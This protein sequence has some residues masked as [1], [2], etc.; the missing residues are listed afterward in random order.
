[1]PA[2]APAVANPDNPANQVVDNNADDNTQNTETIEN[3]E[4]A[5]AEGIGEKKTENIEGDETALSEGIGTQTAKKNWP[6]W[7]I[8]IVAAVTGGTTFGV[9]KGNQKKKA[10]EETKKTDK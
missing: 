3:E 9:I 8:L 10:T 7:W 1:A 4:S 5:L 6:W 2:P